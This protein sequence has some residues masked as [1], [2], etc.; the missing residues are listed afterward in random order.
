MNKKVFEYSLKNNDYNKC[1]EMLR[2]EIINILVK[3]IQVYNKFFKYSTTKDLYLKSK[4]VLDEQYIT[5]SYILYNLDIMNETDEFILD[6]LLEMYKEI[7][8]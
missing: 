7:K 8:K 6:E 4:E 5:I 2:K 3:K 1:I